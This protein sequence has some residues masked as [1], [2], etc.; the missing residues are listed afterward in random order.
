MDRGA[1]QD[2]L[3]AGGGLGVLVLV[4]DEVAELVVDIA[5]KLAAQPIDIDAACAQHRDG[6]LVLGQRQ[7]QMLE[8][9][10]FMATLVRQCERPM[11]RF[12]EIA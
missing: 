5:Q 3:E 1:L 9:R 7:Q 8:R 4:D 2:P 6:V 11:Q 10:V 12:F